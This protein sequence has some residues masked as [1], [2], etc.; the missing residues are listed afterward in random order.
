MLIIVFKCQALTISKDILLPQ[1][2]SRYY[3]GNIQNKY[4]RKYFC[5]LRTLKCA[6]NMAGTLAP[7]LDILNMSVQ[8][9][10]ISKMSVQELDISKMS[11]QELDISKMSVQELDISKMAVQ[12]LDI[13]KM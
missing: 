5:I 10:D 4:Q 7:E 13:S 9:L 8:E 11:V 3:V 6:F 1:K 2:G 12:E